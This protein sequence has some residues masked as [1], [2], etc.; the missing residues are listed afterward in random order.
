MLCE[1][2]L[3]GFVVAKNFYLFIYFERNVYHSMAFLEGCVAI[4]FQQSP[5]LEA[6]LGEFLQFQ[7]SLGKNLYKNLKT[8]SIILT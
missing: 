6:F 2:E 5:L 7:T 1:G 4:V 3:Y 8:Q